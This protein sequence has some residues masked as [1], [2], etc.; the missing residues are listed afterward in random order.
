MKEIK[1]GTMYYNDKTIT[2]YN[3]FS[4]NG[5]D[6]ECDQDFEDLLIALQFI[7]SRFIKFNNGRRSYLLNLDNLLF[8]K[9]YE[10]EN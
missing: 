1:I 3:N 5:D 6:Q 7:S 2:I 10:Q 4:V 9:E 8:V